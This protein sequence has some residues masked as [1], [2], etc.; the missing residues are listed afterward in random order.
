VRSPVPGAKLRIVR[1]RQ[2]QQQQQQGQRQLF[3]QRNSQL[4]L[5]SE[6]ELGSGNCHKKK[7]KK[8][9]NKKNQS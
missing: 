3:I 8:N 5:Q 9:N 4:G 1:R 7:K 6:L 2:Q